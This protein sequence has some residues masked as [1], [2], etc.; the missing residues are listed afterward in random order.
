MLKKN[1]FLGFILSF[2]LFNFG[3]SQTISK[4]GTMAAKFLSV[5]VGA[6]GIAMGSAVTATMDDPSAMYWNP[7]GI[8]NTQEFNGLFTF[9][10]SFADINLNYTAVAFPVDNFGVVGINVTSIDYG[11]MDETTENYPDGTGLT[12]TAASYAFGVTYANYITELFAFGIN[13]KYIR[14]NISKSA[15]DGLAVDIG[16]N[17]LTPFWG[18]KFATS[19]SNYGT[20]MQMSGEDLLKR[21]DSDETTGGNNE[22][23]DV[24]LATDSFELPLRLQLG[25]AKDFIFSEDYRLTLATDIIYPNDN[26]PWMNVGAELSLLDEI[27]QIRGGY[28]T[29]FLEN[30]QK[31]LTAGFGINYDDFGYFGMNI[32]YAYQ[33]FKDLGDIH[34]FGVG[35]RF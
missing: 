13:V 3:F 27:V 35:L 23:V 26:Y 4:T 11:T 18:L 2:L 5:G 30:T 20:K 1:I 24:Y 28:E 12:F 22:S 25:L 9:T 34:S 16:T 31:G 14:E 19:I 6:K 33:Q 17:F 10:K 32:D 7:A 29:L 15:S 8:A 21:L